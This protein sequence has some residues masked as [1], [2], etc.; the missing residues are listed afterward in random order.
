MASI[1]EMIRQARAQ[2]FLD[3]NAESKVC[4]DIIL[5]ALSESSLCR[6]AT[7]KGG[8]V[9][10]SITHDSRRATQDINHDPNELYAW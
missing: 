1:R 7:I 5:K 10:R 2:G 8:V 4:Q 9:M 6:N 3:D